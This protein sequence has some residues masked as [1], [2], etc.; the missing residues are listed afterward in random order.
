MTSVTQ[1]LIAVS[2]GRFILATGEKVGLW[3]SGFDCDVLAL[4][5]VF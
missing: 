2:P 5:L 1:T 3:T 4:E